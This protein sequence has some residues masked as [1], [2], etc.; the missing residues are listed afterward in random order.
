V[1]V[2][3]SLS[4]KFTPDTTLEDVCEFYSSKAN[5]NTDSF[6]F[7]SL[8][9]EDI[10][11]EL[12]LEDMIEPNEDDETNMV[13]FV[14]KKCEEKQ[15]N[16]ASL[17]D[18]KFSFEKMREII[19]GLKLNVKN[20]INNSSDKALNA[21]LLNIRMVLNDLIKNMKINTEKLKQFND[22]D[23]DNIN[24]KN[25]KDKNI[26]KNANNNNINKNVNNNS[27]NKNINNNNIKINN[28][29]TEP[30]NY[31][32]NGG[33]NKNSTH[34]S[35]NNNILNKSYNNMSNIKAQKS[36]NNNKIIDEKKIANQNNN[37]KQNINEI[38]GTI[39]KPKT[40]SDLFDKDPISLFLKKH[41]KKGVDIYFEG[42]KVTDLEKFRYGIYEK[43]REYNFKIVYNYIPKNISKLFEKERYITYLNLTNFN[44]S[45][46]T[47]MSGMFISCSYLKK[48]DGINNFIT[49]NVTNMA[50]MFYYC[51]VLECLNLS[52]FNTSKVTDMSKMFRCC[53]KL[54]KIDGINNFITD[55]VTNMSEMF[56]YC[57]VLEYLDLS[58]FDTSKVTDMSD[59]FRCCYKL[60]KIDGINNFI[61]DNVTNMAEMFEKCY[62]LEYLDL[63][64]FD[65]S[66]VCNMKMMFYECRS[67]KYLNLSNFLVDEY[68]YWRIFDFI[69]N[70]KC[71]IITKSERLQR[72]FKRRQVSCI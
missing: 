72:E 32:A 50:Y 3:V 60:K 13:I 25:I 41:F 46:A 30:N 44:T 53:E 40:L 5:L 11:F 33:N 39:Y 4:A 17:K 14:K 43:G 18:I 22:D 51:E 35:D 9:G 15:S 45:K 54:K 57:E 55:N 28:Y 49:D 70:W 58:N 19:Y 7:S 52:N 29:T 48:I 26:N 20:I 71:R 34:K 37:K 10:D 69:N 8:D 64:N 67:I 42:K 36:L 61:T 65:T 66:N 31:K 6:E 23:C 63:S 1:K 21:Q 2:P 12:T 27:I 47:D 68:C 62:K 59:M 24:D 56:Y 16:T 38:T